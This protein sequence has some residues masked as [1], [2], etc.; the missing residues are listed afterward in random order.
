MWVPS[1]VISWFTSL[2]EDSERNAKTSLEALTYLR[3][4]LASVRAERDSVKLQL[5]VT[6]TNF[7]WL[8]MKVN[9]LEAEKAALLEKLYGMR[10]PVPELIRTPA[11]D[12]TTDDFSFADIGD[13]LAKK[14]GF[15]TY[16]DKA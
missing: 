8:R 14:Y 1:Q 6:Q 4:E 10:V 13:D 16:S 12:P 7:D 3:E 11:K 15:P 5:G 2:K 9:G